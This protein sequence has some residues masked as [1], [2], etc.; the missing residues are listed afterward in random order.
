[1]TAW[2]VMRMSETVE[3]MGVFSTEKLA[4]EACTKWFDCVC[5]IEL[6]KRAPEETTEWPGAY[7]PIA[8]MEPYEG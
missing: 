4:V 5:P 7:Y 1:M 8:L 2:I 3:V 6:D